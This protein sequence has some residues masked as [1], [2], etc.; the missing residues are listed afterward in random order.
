M[1][2]NKGRLSG[3]L[4]KYRKYIGDLDG[5]LS[6]SGLDLLA[7]TRK[8]LE[9]F[10]GPVLHE[11]GITPR[12]RRPYVAGIRTFYKWARANGLVAEDPACALVY[13][14]IGRKLPRGMTLQNAE[15]LLMQPDLHTFI[16]V[17]DSAILHL[18]IG[19]G[20]RLS[21]LAALNEQDLMFTEW[22]GVEHLVLRIV[23]KG[24]KERFVPVPHEARLMVRA[25]LG[26]HDLAGVNRELPDGNK[27]LFVSTANRTVPEHEYF[28]EAR[29]LSDRSI[30]DMLE[31]YARKAGI[32]RD[33]AHPHALRHLY[34]TELMESDVH[35]LKMQTLMGHARTDDT[36]IYAHVALRSLAKAV[37]SANPLAKMKTPASELARRLK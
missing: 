5:W 2:H 28:G 15:R 33:Q 20:L 16:G 6:A 29:R 1:R 19:A 32:P 13:P 22:L 11:R 31:T 23:E 17:R 12:S 24:E 34:G 21:G 3:T 36:K 18:F 35:I 27:V 10:T 8:D 30:Q 37:E 25:Y 14:N 4:T 26:H 9:E 7:A